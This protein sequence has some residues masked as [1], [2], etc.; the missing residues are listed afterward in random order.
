[1]SSRAYFR[2]AC[3]RGR[4]RQSDRCNDLSGVT[5]QNRCSRCSK[6][7]DGNCNTR[8][9]WPLSN[10]FT[11]YTPKSRWSHMTS[12]S[13]P[14]STFTMAGSVVMRLRSHTLDRTAGTSGSM[15]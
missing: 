14:W 1:M 9:A 11:R 3:D 6:P 10:T 5:P 12:L 15:M 8:A 7:K 4:R 2:M 13:Q